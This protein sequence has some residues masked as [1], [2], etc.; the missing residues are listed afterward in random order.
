LFGAGPV[1]G[2]Y[3]LSGG[4]VVIAV[5]KIAWPRGTGLWESHG[6]GD[7]WGL[8]LSASSGNTT[9]QNSHDVLGWWLVPI[10]LVLGT[11]LLYG[12][13]RFGAWAMRLLWPR[14]L[15]YAAGEQ[16]AES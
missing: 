5:L 9:P 8:S 16:R 15:Q 3:G 10:G 4:L 1:S 6:P 12:T 7:H 2:G 11:A 14:K 13:Y